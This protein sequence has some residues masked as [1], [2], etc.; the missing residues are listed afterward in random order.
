MSK[1]LYEEGGHKC[2]MF[3]DLV[4]GMGIQANQFLIIDD[5]SSAILDPGGPLTYH[6]LLTASLKHTSMENLKYIVASHQDPDIIS[7]LGMWLQFSQAEIVC[8]DL[9]IRFLPHLVT[10]TVQEGRRGS[11]IGNRLLSVPDMGKRL[12]F[13]KTELI[14]LPAHFLHSVGNVNVYDPVSKILFSG[15]MGASVGEDEIGYD[16]EDFHAHT[17]YMQQFHQRYMSS[18]RACRLWANMVRQLNVEM[19][20]PQHGRCFIGR[21]M[22]D[23]FLD[24]ISSIECGTDLLTEKHYHLPE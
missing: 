3:N 15:D 2:V 9:W 17:K 7:S 13:G 22:V 24:W 21:G 11:D 16:V 12:L 18:S 23:A 20:V 8:S 14:L 10:T 19:I 5:R 1:V 4:K 6:P